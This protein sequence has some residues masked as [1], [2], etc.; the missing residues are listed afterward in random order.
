MSAYQSLRSIVEGCEKDVNK[1]YENQRDL[2]VGHRFDRVLF[3]GA[4]GA[5]ACLVGQFRN[6]KDGCEFFLSDHFAVLALVDVD[7]AYLGKR[8][9]GVIRNRRAVPA[10]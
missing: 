7:N 9:A 10:R 2:R 1:F 6:L 3:R 4:V 5:C 8:G